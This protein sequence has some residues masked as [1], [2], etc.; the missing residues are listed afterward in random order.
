MLAGLCLVAFILRAWRLDFQSFWQDEGFSVSLSGSSV[1]YI[2]QQS[3]TVEPN[4]PLYFLLL[5]FWRLPAGS[6]EYAIRFL[7]L[8]PSVLAVP[9]MFLLGRQLWCER[10][11][12]VAAALAAV[13]PFL[14]WLAQEARM[15]TWEALWLTLGAWF[16][17]RGLRSGRSAYWLLFSSCNLLAVYSHLYAVFVVA[18]EAL[19]LVALC[20]RVWR[21]AA[22]AIGAP[23]VLF[24]PWFVSV[25][26]YSGESSTWRGFIGVWDMVRVLLLNAASQGHLPGRV[27]GGFSLLLGLAVVLGF[28]VLVKARPRSGWLLASWL[29]LPVAAV[30]ALSFKEPLF[31]PRY[32]VV[33]LPAL[34][35]LAAGA[36]AALPGKVALLGLALLSSGSIWAVERGNTV[37]AY[38]KEDYRLAGTYIGARTDTHDVVLL[39]A[40]YIVYPFEYYFRG[41]GTM[42]P[43]NVEP[44]TNVGPVL[45]PLAG[46]YDHIWLVE[47]HDIFVDPHNHV[48]SWLRARY[49]LADERYITGIHF[50]EFDPHAQLASLPATA[51]PLQ[52]QWAGGPELAGY[53]LRGGNPSGI[54]LYWKGNGPLAA[55]YHLSLKLWSASGKLAG[56]QDGEPLNA[57]LRFGSFPFTGYVRDDHYIS[58][59]PGTY[60]LRLSVYLQQD[61]PIQ[62]HRGS[63]VDFGQVTVPAAHRA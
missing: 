16:L 32:F 60:D 6:T 38:A 21:P 4:P 63:Q 29:L 5:H 13:S 36:V 35:L 58:A 51:R 26:A 8:I 54:R 52:V 61:L 27:D 12:L 41:P 20:R 42:L 46:K 34:L 19:L 9:A 45:A 33:I 40:N 14:V 28:G 48:A 49:R 11:G 25:S 2:L 59:A 37:P 22:L 47:A 3:F 18:A 62:G 43:L 7:S 39:V 31:S 53:Q 57:G 44:E 55:N 50:M 1:G 15:Y 10:L 24:V 56:Q 17:L 23:I 30:Y